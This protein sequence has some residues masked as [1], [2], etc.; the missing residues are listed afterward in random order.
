MPVH[1][2]N[3]IINGSSKDDKRPKMLQQIFNGERA[4]ASGCHMKAP[5]ARICYLLDEDNQLTIDYYN[6]LSEA[7]AAEVKMKTGQDARNV[8]WSYFEKRW[9]QL[10][11][12]PNDAI[13]GILALIA[14]KGDLYTRSYISFATQYLAPETKDYINTFFAFEGG[15]RI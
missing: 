12:E 1:Y 4:W 14:A 6:S 8:T 2:H 9:Q 3:P 13:K 5:L 11:Q 15:D 10:D 7:E